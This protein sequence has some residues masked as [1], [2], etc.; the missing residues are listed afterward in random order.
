VESFGNQV[1]LVAT[2]RIERRVGS[3][4]QRGVRSIKAGRLGLAMPNNE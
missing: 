3:A 2:A 1:S 4:G